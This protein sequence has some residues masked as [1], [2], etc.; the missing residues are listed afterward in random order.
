MS[1]QA[2]AGTIT[3]PGTQRRAFGGEAMITV[4]IMLATIMQVL[5]TTIANVALPHMQGSLGA[6]SDQITWVL[7]SY[8]VAAAIMTPPVGYLAQR[9]GRRQVFLWSVGGFTVTSMLC[10][11]AGSLNEMILWRLLQG[12]F[13]ASL[14]PLS[15]ATLLDTFPKE[16]HASAMSIWGVG[17]MIGPV[18]GPTLG[19]WLT[20]YY[21]WRWVF[22]INL[23][24]GILSMLGIYFCVPESETRRQRFDGLGFGLLALAVGALQM[25]LDRGEQVEWFEAL[26]IQ[27]Y[28]IA[29]VLGLYLFLVHSR[30]TSTPFLSPE[31]FRDR[32]YVSGL[33]FIF[34]VGIIL[35]A[36]MALLPPFL[37]QWKGYPVVTTGLV[38]MPRGV[39]TMI[40]MMVVGKLMQRFDARALI[41]LGMGLV[42]FSLWE[43]TGFNLQVGQRDL[44]Y[45][46]VVQGLGLGLVF[47]PISTLAYATLEPRFRGE[48]T[49]LFSLSRNLGSSIGVSIVMAALTRNLWINQQQL[50]ERVQLPAGTLNGLPAADSIAAL[51]GALMEEVTRQAAEIAYVNDFQMLMWINM[52]A[53]PLVFLLRNPDRHG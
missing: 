29:A 47:V 14:V 8:I 44:I 20:E 25:L 33:I 13:G 46:G 24:F 23:P 11:Q 12:L 1:Q 28:A 41:L 40:S 51:P 26:E 36:T 10:G 35:L 16:R 31:L 52:L 19:G 18:L 53:M 50:G 7:T 48:A 9:F 27:L 30:T 3:A 32:N 37:Q 6:G 45:T 39:G 34:I 22:Y 15:Q 4:S 5:D 17:V 21:S 42:S 2:Q 43:M 49:A 38:L